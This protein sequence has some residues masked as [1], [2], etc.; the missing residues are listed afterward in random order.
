MLRVQRRIRR[1]QFCVY[2]DANNGKSNILKIITDENGLWQFSGIMTSFLQHI[3]FLG[4][5]YLPEYKISSGKGGIVWRNR[6]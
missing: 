6:N 2:L 5:I 1:R 4:N 3:E